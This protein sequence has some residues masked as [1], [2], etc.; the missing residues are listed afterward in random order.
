MSSGLLSQAPHDPLLDRIQ[1]FTGLAHDGD[2][3]APGR[4]LSQSARGGRLVELWGSLQQTGV[5]TG[6]LLGDALA[7]GW[8]AG[9]DLAGSP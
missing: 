8:I 7:K 6:R 9:F 1:R 2:T 3:A 5:A 4:N